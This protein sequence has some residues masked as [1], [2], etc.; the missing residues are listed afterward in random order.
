MTPDPKWLEILKASGWQTTALAAAFSV[1][2]LVIRIGWIVSPDPWFA[3]FCA[4]A[5]LICLL[6]ARASI[7]HAIADFLHPRVWL[8]RWVRQKRQRKI[9]REYTPFM[10]EQEKPILAY[11]FAKNQLLES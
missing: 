8:A 3:A 11:L 6:L 9:V 2:L 4:L 5:L 7:G 1:I 10:T